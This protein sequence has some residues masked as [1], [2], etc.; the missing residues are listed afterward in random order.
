MALPVRDMTWPPPAVAKE[1]E[2]VGEYAAEYAG[3]RRPRNYPGSDMRPP[4][5]NRIGAVLNLFRGVAPSPATGWTESDPLH[6]PIA[7]DLARTSADLLFSEEPKI[8]VELLNPPAPPPPVAPP[9]DGSTPPAPPGEDGEEDE[10]PAQERYDDIEDAIGLEAMLVESGELCAALSGIYWRISWDPRL[11]DHPFPTFVQPDNAWPEWS[12]GRLTA[13]TFWR[14]LPGRDPGDDQQTDKDRTIWRHLERH[15]V[16]ISTLGIRTTMIEHGLYRGTPDKLGVRLPL[17]DHPETSGI[18][19]NRPDLS[20]F[21]IG[22]V[23]LTA[24]YIPNMRPNRV[25]RGSPFGR[26]DIEQLGGVLRAIDDTWT[27]WM[28]DLRLAKARLIVPEGYLRVGDPGQGSTFD[29]DREIYEPLPM[30][31]PDG[32]GQTGITIVQFAIRT[33]EH[34]ATLR[35]LIQQVVTSAGY[36]LRSFGMGETDMAPATATQVDAEQSLSNITREKKTRYWSAGLRDMVRALLLTDYALKFPGSVEIDPASVEVE[37]DPEVDEDP[38]K[39]A[40]TVQ[41]WANAA[42]A[43]TYTKVRAL[44]PEWGD[45][46]VQAET[47]RIQQESG[48]P[49]ADPTAVGAMVNQPLQPGDLATMDAMMSDGTMPDGMPGQPQMTIGQQPGGIFPVPIGS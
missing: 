36:S 18:T 40:Q 41:A 10:N 15:S 34:Q 44:H 23:G 47:D 20:A 25:D 14:V 6:V 32:A 12:W 30:M 4:G 3:R 26:P 7:A 22:D 37:F 17:T 11:F 35:A 45:N 1:I 9:A 46:E 38:L 39:L 29:V 33:A 5:G 49:A 8:C 43:S 31:P 2:R 19:L 28:R 16:E 21:V 27:S 42:A 24:G 48:L 13:V